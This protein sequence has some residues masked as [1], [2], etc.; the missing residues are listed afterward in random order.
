MRKLAIKKLSPINR[1]NLNYQRKI[2]NVL[3]LL[4]STQKKVAQERLPFLLSK[5]PDPLPLIQPSPRVRRNLNVGVRL[6]P[7]P[8]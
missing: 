5:T 1:S 2:K 8:A 3:F 6:R 4:L 7:C